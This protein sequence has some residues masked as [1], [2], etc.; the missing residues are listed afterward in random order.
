M[1]DHH[2]QNRE[3]SPAWHHCRPGGFPCFRATA[4]VIPAPL[5][6]S[7]KHRKTSSTAFISFHN[8]LITSPP[9]R[10]FVEKKLLTWLFDRLPSQNNEIAH[11]SVLQIRQGQMLQ[12]PMQLSKPCVGSL[13][14]I[15]TGRDQCKLT[16]SPYI[17]SFPRAQTHRNLPFDCGGAN[18]LERSEFLSR[19]EA[20]NN[21]TTALLKFS[22]NL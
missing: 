16:P 17:S 14:A 9:S 5:W 2:E 10:L 22:K 11:A 15:P 6:P 7:E 13:G 21:Q 4:S 20:R 1:P 18:H 12:S 3:F 8:L 19:N